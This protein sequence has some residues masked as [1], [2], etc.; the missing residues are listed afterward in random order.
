MFFG[1]PFHGADGLNQGEMLAAAL[2]HYSRDVTH[3]RTLQILMPGDPYLT[4]L[5]NDFTETVLSAEN[6]P[7]IACFFEMNP[8]DVGQIFDESRKV[9]TPH[10]PGRLRLI[11]AR[12]T[13]S[14]SPRAVSKAAKRH[15]NWA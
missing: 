4:R 8:T 2:H 6:R 12:L 11:Q 5:V 1:T 7:Q 3:T 9:F 14:V 10:I 15:V 13:Q